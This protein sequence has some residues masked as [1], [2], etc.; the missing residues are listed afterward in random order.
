[1]RTSFVMGAFATLMVLGGCTASADTSAAEAGVA[2]F[3]RMLAEGRVAD[4]YRGSSSEMQSSTSEAQLTQL[5]TA[6]R[7]RL[8]AL[9]S[10]D[11]SG[12]HWNTN[13]GVTLVTLNY[14][15]RY[16]GGEAEERFVYRVGGGRATLAGYHIN[17]MALISNAAP[18]AAPADVA[19]PDK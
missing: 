14:N 5:L 15:A 17:S 6:V 18:A 3:R 16:A 10:A 1:M 12:W 9:E 13:N 7:D 19:A 4:I 11:R 8:G 2:E